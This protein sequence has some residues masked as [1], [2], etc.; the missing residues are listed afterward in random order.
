MSI[1]EDG[2]F[3]TRRIFFVSASPEIDL[4]ALGRFDVFRVR[5]DVEFTGGTIQDAGLL[6]G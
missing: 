1:S 5:L 3:V 2:G 6:G 4:K